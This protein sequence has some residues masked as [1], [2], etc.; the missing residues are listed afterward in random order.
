MEEMKTLKQIIGKL[1]ILGEL[2]GENQVSLDLKE[3]LELD[4]DNLS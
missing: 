3:N 4:Q 1:K 2:V